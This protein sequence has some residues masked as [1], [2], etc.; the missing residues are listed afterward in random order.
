VLKIPGIGVLKK[1]GIKRIA[2]IKAGLRIYLDETITFLD[3]VG[4][5]IE[6]ANR[7]IDE[8]QEWF[9]REL[10]RRQRQLEE[11]NKE[12]EEAEQFLRNMRKL[13]GE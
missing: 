7:K 11:L 5:E 2:D 9:N 6:E 10:D 1:T 4:V 13:L 12:R 3:Q 8:L